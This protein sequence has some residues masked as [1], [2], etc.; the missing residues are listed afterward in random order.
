MVTSLNPYLTDVIEKNP[1]W[2]LV[3]E[4]YELYILDK[5]MFIVVDIQH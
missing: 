2:N 1:V 5:L 3:Q 4:Y